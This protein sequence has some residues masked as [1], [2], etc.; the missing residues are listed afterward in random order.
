MITKRLQNK[1]IPF[2]AFAN[3]AGKIYVKQKSVTDGRYNIQ[4]VTF[5][6]VIF[7]KNEGWT[8]KSCKNYLQN[9]PKWII[10]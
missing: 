1:Y 5:S 9:F 7:Y 3:F 6:L 10:L 4:N 2:A 8:Q